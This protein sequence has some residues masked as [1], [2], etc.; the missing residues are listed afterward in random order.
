MQVYKIDK[1]PT[2]ITAVHG[3][4]AKGFVLENNVNLKPCYIAK[5]GDFFAHGKTLKQA[6]EDA[7]NKYD[8]NKPLEDRIADFKEQYPTLDTKGDNADLFKWHNILTG[9]CK[10]GRK[11]FC[12]SRGVDWESGK[13]S[14]RDF[15]ELCKDAFGSEQIKQLEQSY[16]N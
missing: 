4:H 14:V 7:K 5:C 3:D 16:E 8:Q 10:F 6:Q 12:M 1:V 9:S 15:I 11:S 2:I 13:T